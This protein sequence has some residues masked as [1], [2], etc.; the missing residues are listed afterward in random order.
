MKK[1]SCPLGVEVDG[2]KRAWLSGMLRTLRHARIL[3]DIETIHALDVNFLRRG[4]DDVGGALLAEPEERRSQLIGVPR[5][6]QNID[7]SQH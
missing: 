3:R 1:D 5:L 4:N 7:E 6:V 2:G